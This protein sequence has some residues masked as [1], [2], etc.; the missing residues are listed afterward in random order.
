ME[1]LPGHVGGQIAA[2]EKNRVADFLRRPKTR[3][4]NLP[5]PLG[6]YRFGHGFPKLG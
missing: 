1:R 5:E 2:K 3:E 4:G 6:L